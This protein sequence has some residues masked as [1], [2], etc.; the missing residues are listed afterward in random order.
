[1]RHHRDAA[2]AFDLVGQITG[3][4]GVEVAVAH[5][6]IHFARGVGQENRCLSG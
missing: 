5:Q 2:V 6:Q 1:V 4:L 3:H